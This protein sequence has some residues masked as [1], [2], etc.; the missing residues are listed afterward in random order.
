MF[1]IRILAVFALIGAFPAGCKTAE[2]SGTG[3]TPHAAPA[4]N[5]GDRDSNREGM[6]CI[7]G[8]TRD[9]NLPEM[10]RRDRIDRDFIKVLTSHAYA[11]RLAYDEDSIIKRQAALWG[12]PRADVIHAGGMTAFVMSNSKC[13][14]LSFRGTDTYSLDWLVDLKATPESVGRGKMHKGFREGW[15]A[16]AERV[17]D[18][19]AHHDAGK[20]V[21]WVTGHSLGG[22]LAGVYAYFGQFGESYRPSLFSRTR[23]VY[24]PRIDT[25]VT[26]GQPL[27]A[28]S[29]LA[30]AMR[31]EFLGRYFRVVNK[32]DPFASVP[33]WFTHFGSLLWMQDDA[34]E[35]SNDKLRTSGP[36][37]V[38]SV[39]PAPIPAELEATR[40]ATE[41][42]RE[43]IR[44]SEGHRIRVRDEPIYGDDWSARF[45]DHSMDQY[46][47]RLTS[48]LRR[49]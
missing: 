30:K 11:A 3:A 18:A 45:D 47:S 17:R 36:G 44:R 5:E 4:S 32:T 24:G 41:A 9:D 19:V 31:I 13:A 35:Y 37:G 43:A 34:L 12:Y 27:W 48:E 38:P 46:L 14:V 42:L 1:Y 21:F 2:V 29:E 23:T 49:D 6:A 26:F 20:K 39:D 25:V 33:Y 22:A 15:S 28:D 7:F 40:A 10:A 8:A 16:L